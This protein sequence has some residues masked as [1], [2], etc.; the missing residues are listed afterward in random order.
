ME[1]TILALPVLPSP[2]VL[3]RVCVCVCPC[4]Q[5][6]GSGCTLLGL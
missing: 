4:V 6:S 5:V 2:P 3:A 1:L